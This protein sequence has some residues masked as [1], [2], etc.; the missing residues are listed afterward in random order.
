MYEIFYLLVNKFYSLGNEIPSTAM[1][2]SG[3]SYHTIE[4]VLNEFSIK[5]VACPL[6]VVDR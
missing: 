4:R 1:V 6:I 3:A 5:I 2:F